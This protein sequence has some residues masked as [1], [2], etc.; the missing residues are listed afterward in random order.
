MD[1]KAPFVA[2]TERRA[3]AWARR[4]AIG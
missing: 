1:A 4:T 2:E 3:L